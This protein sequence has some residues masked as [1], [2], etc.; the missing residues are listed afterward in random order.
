MN[1]DLELAVIGAGPYGLALGSRLRPGSA[2]VFG[3]PMETWLS[4]QPDMELRARWDEM[5]LAHQDERG[6]LAEWSA[7]EG[8]PPR[9]PMAVQDFVDYASWFR[10]TYVPSLV[11]ERVE[12]VEAAGRGFRVSTATAAFDV[13]SVAIAV[14]ITPFP[15]IPE[16]YRGLEDERVA[17][18]PSVKDFSS[19]LGLRVAVVG[20][21]QSA[22]ETASCAAR[23][24]AEV[25]LLVRGRIHWFAD[26]EPYHQRGRLGSWAFRIAYPAVGYGP[27]PLNRLVLHPDLFAAAPRALRLRLTQRLLRPGASAWLR[28][29]VTGAV[30]I[31]EKCDVI[32]VEAQTSGIQ[33]RLSDGQAL[34]VDRLLVA[35]G[36]HFDIER[37]GFLDASLRRSVS[38]EHG[39]PVLDRWFR[40]TNSGIAFLGYPAEGRF[41]PLARFVLGVPFTAG[42]V[43]SRYEAW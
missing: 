30:K 24:G 39:W 32:D 31:R 33:L 2:T 18:A 17:P 42:R 28:G 16:V 23:A 4:M 1:A 20:G 15:S 41:G 21:G 13:R 29:L 26:R 8:R 14:G 25:T 7:A 5:S 27:P 11:E 34:E 12:K 10:H 40:S 9:E 6:S 38:V 37:L 22:I 19:L 3:P 35:T 36:Y 43:A